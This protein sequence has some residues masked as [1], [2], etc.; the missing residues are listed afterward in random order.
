MKHFWIQD[1]FFLFSNF[2]FCQIFW[3]PSSI[4]GIQYNLSEFFPLKF[5]FLIL[6]LNKHKVKW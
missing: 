6:F 5:T 3:I 2:D 1:D 4:K